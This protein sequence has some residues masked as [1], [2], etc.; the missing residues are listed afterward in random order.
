MRDDCLGGSK[1]EVLRSGRSRGTR[2]QKD[3]M[4]GE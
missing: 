1:V 4:A 2:A 3:G